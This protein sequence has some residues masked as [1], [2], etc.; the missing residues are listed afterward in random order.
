MVKLE[1]YNMKHAVAALRI[2]AIPVTRWH[3]ERGGA[4][5]QVIEMWKSAEPVLAEDVNR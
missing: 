1:R 3:R 4:D 2:S 5:C